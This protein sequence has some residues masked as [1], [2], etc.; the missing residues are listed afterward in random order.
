[1]KSEIGQ[2]PFGPRPVDQSASSGPLGFWRFEKRAKRSAR[3]LIV[4]VAVVVPVIA[5]FTAAGYAGKHDRVL[6]TRLSY[7]STAPAVARL[8]AH[9][10]T[11]IGSARAGTYRLIIE[12]NDGLSPIYRFISSARRS[13]E[14]TMYELNDPH[15]DTLLAAD[16]ER[17]VDVRVILDRHYEQSA[18]QPAFAYLTHHRVHVRWAPSSYDLTHQ[19]SIVVDNKE[20]LILTM[21]LTRQYYSSS[22]DVGVFD[23]NLADVRAI[24]DVFNHDFAGDRSSPEP[25]GAD[26]VWS[27]G[28]DA[29]LVRLIDSARHR[30][31]VE[32]EEM[33][34]YTIVDALCAAARRG[35]NVEVVMT[36]QSSWYSNF[37]KL[38]RA[39]VHLRTYAPSARIYIHAKLIDVDPGYRDGQVD[40]GSQNFSWASLEYNRELGIILRSAAIEKEVAKVVAHDFAGGRPWTA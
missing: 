11:L 28:A 19:K 27:P 1:M 22:R 17:G 40:I 8:T 39:G 26:L 37:N 14:M 6:Q 15:A 20:A 35:V 24:A 30:L 21:N 29:R 9:R 31:F 16:A 7:G 33:S 10:T 32:D 38:V 18:N 13:L 23:S 5:S 36:R 34:E 3:E 2:V 4:I 12:P 25:S